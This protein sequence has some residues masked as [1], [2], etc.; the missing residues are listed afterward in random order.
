LVLYKVNGKNL[1]KSEFERV[2]L[3][4]GKKVVYFEEHSNELHNENICLRYN[5]SKGKNAAN[6]S[7][8]RSLENELYICEG[9]S[10]RTIL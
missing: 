4:K 5:S 2:R 1:L 8:I 10:K 9:A 6:N 3:K 7:L